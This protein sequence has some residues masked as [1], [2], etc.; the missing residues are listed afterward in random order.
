MDARLRIL[1]MVKYA[2]IILFFYMQCTGEK[3]SN[4]NMISEKQLG[5]SSD[6][7]EVL[8]AVQMN[9]TS[10]DS[11]MENKVSWVEKKKE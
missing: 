11:I 4:S 7:Q 3:V 2:I 9:K 6:E 5:K 8:K 1:L 10:K